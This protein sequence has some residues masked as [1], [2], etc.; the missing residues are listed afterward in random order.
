MRE[1][2]HLIDFTSAFTVVIKMYF[3]SLQNSSLFILDQRKTLPQTLFCVLVVPWKFFKKCRRI[4]PVFIPYHDLVKRHLS[5][6]GANS[7]RCCILVISRS[8]SV[9]NTP[10]LSVQ[11]SWWLC[12]DI[13]FVRSFLRKTSCCNCSQESHHHRKSLQ[14]SQAL[15]KGTVDLP[16]LLDLGLDHPF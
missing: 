16:V 2:K 13:C 7:L 3:C 5:D 4:S 10:K 11:Y 12:L 1:I 14:K 6:K 9:L 15:E 8:N